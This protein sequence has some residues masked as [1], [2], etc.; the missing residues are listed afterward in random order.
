M[1]AKI[2]KNVWIA[3]CIVVLIITLF[4]GDVEMGRDIDVFLI[5]SMMI[6]AFPFGFI[7]TL[8]YVSLLYVLFNL[9]GVSLSLESYL[10]FYGNLFL[11]WFV[12]FVTGYLQWFNFLP[13][14]I[15]KIRS[16]KLR[17]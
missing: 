13:W 8:I 15:E 17:E 12:L 16:K 6:L 9:F 1:I 10:G 5:W 14:V 4:Y 2:L 3:L 7:I 11:T